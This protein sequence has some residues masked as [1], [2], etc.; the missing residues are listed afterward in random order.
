MKTAVS[1]YRA[2]YVRGEGTLD[3]VDWKPRSVFWQRAQ[4]DV[5]YAVDGVI[6]SGCVTPPRLPVH[7]RCE[8]DRLW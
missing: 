6:T 2:L 5:A 7:R 1:T 3:P 8:I 4:L